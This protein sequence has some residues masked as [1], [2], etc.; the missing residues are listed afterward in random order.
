M[1]DTLYF[2]VI[3]ADNIDWD[4]TQNEV[5][6]QKT[7]DVYGTLIGATVVKYMSI[8]GHFSPFFVIL[9]I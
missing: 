3:H 5:R 9:A 1:F 4:A 6:G 2:L 7:T 8:L